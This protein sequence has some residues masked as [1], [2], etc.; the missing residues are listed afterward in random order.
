MC[1]H[2]T[3]GVGVPGPALEGYQML[4]RIL[5]ELSGTQ[6]DGYRR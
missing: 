5:T 1:A 4:P 3:V 6:K 2:H